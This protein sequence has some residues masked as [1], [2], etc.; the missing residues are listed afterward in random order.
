MDK[1]RFPHGYKVYLPLAV[2]FVF[3]FLFMPRTGNFKYD[4]KK[5][6]PWMYETLISQFDFPILKTAAQLQEEREKAG[7]GVIPYYRYSE[8]VADEKMHAVESANLGDRNLYP[9]GQ[10][11]FQISRI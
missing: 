1:V 6:S 8:G 11:G 3:I 5:G 4:Y 2:L 10:K 7:S 9:E